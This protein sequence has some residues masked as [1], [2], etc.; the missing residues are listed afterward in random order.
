MTDLPGPPGPPADPWPARRTALIVACALFMQNLDSTV[1]ATALPAMARAFG[2]SPLHMN[3][4]LTSYLV[5]LAIFIPVSG[6]IADRLGSRTVFC[7][8]IAVFTLASVLCGRAES[9]PT[10]VAARALQGAGGAL[11]VPVGRLILLQSVAKPQLVAAM[12]WLTVPSLVGPVVG[13]P[14]GGLIVTYADWRWIFNINVPIGLLGIALALRYMPDAPGVARAR[15]DVR[16][17]LLSSTALACLMVGFETAGRDLLPAPVTAALILVGLLAGAGYALHA[18]RRADPLLD[19]SLMRVPTFAVSVTSGSLFR[20]GVGA[21]P[22]LLPLTLQFGFGKSPAESGFI[23]FASSAGALAMKPVTQ[24]LLRRFGFRAILV[25]NGALSAAL[26]GACAGFDASWPAAGLV[27]VLLIGGFARS[28]QFTA[29]NV[30]AYA[31]IPRARLS[32]ATTL[33]ATLQQVS[34][35]LGI[36]AGAAAL[37]ASA[38]LSGRGE[39]ANADFSAAFLAVAAISLLASP[40]ALVLR[41]N[42]GAELSLHR[43]AA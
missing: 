34:L 28:L 43:A 32:A 40:A 21:L 1:V 14:L 23:T 6:W 17:L 20:V 36:T 16:G 5:S 22:F 4:A 30:L 8:A 15:F 2:A 41:P 25:W 39:P 31:D 10:L 24:A 9:L 11:M 27:A 42:A 35:T 12:A 38:A 26:I 29:F 37:A 13:P 3:V 7:A 19:F 18:R 33:Y